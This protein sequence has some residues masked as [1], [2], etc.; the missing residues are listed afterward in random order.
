MQIDETLQYHWKFSQL[1]M[2]A[3]GMESII[4]NFQDWV[5][6]TTGSGQ[7][8]IVFSKNSKFEGSG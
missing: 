2:M 8:E 5:T 7:E 4:I 6:E 3:M 1:I